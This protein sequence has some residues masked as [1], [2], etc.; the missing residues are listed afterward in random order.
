[1]LLD[2][3][4]RSYRERAV[5]TFEHLRGGD[6]TAV[7]VRRQVGLRYSR[8]PSQLGLAETHGPRLR[9][10]VHELS[11]TRVIASDMDSLDSVD[12]TASPAA[13]PALPP[14]VPHGADQVSM[15]IGQ[16]AGRKRL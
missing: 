15:G 12:A 3:C 2:P 9:S 5:D 6:P 10:D 14:P 16:K 8:G 11:V 1:M 13:E 7:L 4:G